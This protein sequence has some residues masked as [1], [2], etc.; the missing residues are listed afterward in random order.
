MEASQFDLN[1]LKAGKNTFAR[2]VRTSSASH[3]D[4]RR[5]RKAASGQLS[6]MTNRHL[7]GTVAGDELLAALD[8]TMSASGGSCGSVP[9]KRPREV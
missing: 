4:S 6:L 8:A 9:R 7:E 2:G 5:S 1:G 3:Y